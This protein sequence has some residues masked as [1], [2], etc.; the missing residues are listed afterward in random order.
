MS[1]SGR[2]TVTETIDVDCDVTIY[3]DDVIE[4]IKHHATDSDLQ[5]ISNH[6]RGIETKALKTIVD[7]MK[8]QLMLKAMDKYSLEE[9]ET[10]LEMNYL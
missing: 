9:L 7:V 6:V 3:V 5:Q 4:F 1:K 8:H 2:M 10:R